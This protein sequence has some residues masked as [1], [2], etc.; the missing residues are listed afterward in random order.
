LAPLHT[1]GTIVV[2]MCLMIRL[3]QFVRSRTRGG[4][5]AVGLAYSLAVQALIASVGLGMS[6]G[7]TPERA[8]L[9]LCSFALTQSSK[10]PVRDDGPAKPTPVPQ[11]PFCFIAAQSAGDIA[12]LGQAPAL[13]AYAGLPVV[14]ISDAIGDGAFVSQFR[15]T[16]GEPRAPPDFSV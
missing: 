5:L 16:H 3:R 4:L 1:V 10:A 15:H 12:T 7:A 11:C 2:L 9:V 8:D 13:P 6:A 14:A